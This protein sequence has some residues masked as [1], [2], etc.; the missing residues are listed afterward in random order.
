MTAALGKRHLGAWGA[1]AFRGNGRRVSA[2]RGRAGHRW[3]AGRRGD[4]V[5]YEQPLS[6]L[7]LV[8]RTLAAVG[9]AD[10]QPDVRNEVG[11][12]LSR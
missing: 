5:S 10:L 12:F 11:A 9:R 1:G 7:D 3:A 2:R 8:V 6:V 4:N